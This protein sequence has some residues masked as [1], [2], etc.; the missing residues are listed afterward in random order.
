MS[1]F[2]FDLRFLTGFGL[3]AFLTGVGTGCVI[4]YLDRHISPI[5]SPHFHYTPPSR[6]KNTRLHP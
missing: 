3:I 4:M 1:D 6:K 5:A 2:L